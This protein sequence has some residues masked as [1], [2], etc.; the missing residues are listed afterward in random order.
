[1]CCCLEAPR[2]AV[3]ALGTLR[4]AG[5]A[6][7]HRIKSLPEV[8]VL[9]QTTLAQPV[10]APANQANNTDWHFLSLNAQGRDFPIGMFGKEKESW[11][12]FVVASAALGCALYAL[13]R[14]HTPHSATKCDND[15]A[16]QGNEQRCQDE[17]QDRAVL[18][19]DPKDR[20]LHERFMREAIAMVNNTTPRFAHSHATL[21]IGIILSFHQPG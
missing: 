21:A 6:M 5:V 19:M 3:D 10:L 11:T 4:K 18:A 12:T 13:L 16:S 2:R 1:M 8:H 14:G 15:A 7:H 17:D 20:A 9:W